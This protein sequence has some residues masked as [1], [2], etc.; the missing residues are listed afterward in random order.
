MI[1]T[2]HGLA[3]AAGL[4]VLQDGGNAVDAIL[5]AA[6]VLGVVLP[7]TS[8]IG[9]DTFAVYYDAGERRVHA[10]NASGPAP[11]A[12]SVE[13]LHR[14]GHD[15]LPFRGMLSPTVPGAVD[16]MTTMLERW[17]SGKFDLAAILAPAIHYAENGAPIGANI[18]LR[19]EDQVELLSHYPTSRAV[20]LRDDGKMYPLGSLHRQRDLA[21][22]LRLLARGGRDVL[23]GGELAER[24]VAYS[25]AHGGVFALE[26]FASYRCEV[27]EPLAVQYHNHTIYTNP[28]PSQGLIL[29]EAL[30]IVEPFD[31]ASYGFGSVEAVHALVEAKKLA[32][33]DRNAYF[34]DPA[35]V[36]NPT[37]QVLSKR[38]ASHR[39]AEFDPDR[40]IHAPKPGALPEREGDTTYLCAADRDGNMVSLITSISASFGCGEVVEGTGILLNNRGGRGFRMD[41]GHPNTLLPGRRTMHTLSAYFVELASGAKL[42]GG[43]PGGDAQPQWNLQVLTNVLDFDMNVQ[44]AI[45]A[46]RWES[47]PGTDPAGLDEPFRLQLEPGFA[48]ETH[49]A[50]ATRGHALSDA[51]P[52]RGGS[53][54]LIMR[55]W[56]RAYFGGT[57]HRTDGGVLGI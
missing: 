46:P 31:L 15:A 45:D 13:T 24:I 6:N 18:W 16:A 12:L 25:K 51:D 39:R 19:W 48:P 53:V 28:P 54:Q 32:Y 52:A 23:Y 33:A 44:E 30:N 47:T 4:R 1:S 9:G 49:D 57:D 38:F 8:G 36:A 11:R 21:Q 20:F 42:A 5:T 50:L 10:V 26:D 55:T 22:S 41:H 56:D 14:L 2:A 3:T 29:L 43:T 17:G 7:T 37:A 35:F 34:G 40:A 27:V